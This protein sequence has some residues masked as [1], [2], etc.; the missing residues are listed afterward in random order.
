MLAQEAVGNFPDDV[1]C[2]GMGVYGHFHS[3]EPPTVQSFN[4]A[5]GATAG[6][7]RLDVVYHGERRPF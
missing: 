6:V 3:F 2:G 7:L 5:A 1:F 4:L